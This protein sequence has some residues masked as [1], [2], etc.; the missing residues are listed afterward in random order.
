MAD[1]T[2]EGFDTPLGKAGNKDGLSAYYKVLKE[3]YSDTNDVKPFNFY[4]FTY[5]YKSMRTDGKTG[6]QFAFYD[7]KPLI[8]LY[9]GRNGI[10]DALN[11]HFLPVTVRMKW[12]DVLEQL[13]GGSLSEGRFSTLQADLIK[14]IGLKTQFAER[15]YSEDRIAEWKKIQP[16]AI[17]ELCQWTAP[18]FGNVSYH[19]IETAYKIYQR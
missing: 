17:R 15:H 10:I 12:L 2:L 16:D 19:L 13:S 3:S 9:G 5:R 11:L 6:N 18:T 4:T 7:V 1:T 14:E 8:F